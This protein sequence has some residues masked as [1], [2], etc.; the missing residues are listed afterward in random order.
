M[1]ESFAKLHEDICFGK[2]GRKVIWQPRIDCWISDKLFADGELPG[3][4]KGMSKVELY[5]ELGCSARIYE[6]NACIRSVYDESLRFRTEDDGTT[7][8]RYIDTPLGTVS[9]KLRR[10]PNTWAAGTE[11]G[12][13]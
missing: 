1:T 11:S 4:Y 10:S 12:L 2:A 3:K 6:Y 5:K 8:T 7:V 13:F 9:Q